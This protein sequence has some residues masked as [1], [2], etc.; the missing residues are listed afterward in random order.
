MDTARERMRNDMELRRYSKITIDE[1]LRIIETFSEFHHR[2]PEKLGEREIE[3]YLLDVAS[4]TGPANQKM[5]VAALKFLYSTTLSKPELVRKIPWPRVPW[6]VRE[7]LTACE[8]D[9]ILAS[10]SSPKHR[11]ILAI[12]YSAGLRIGEAL[13]LSCED[14]DTNRGLIYIRK[15]KNGSPRYVMLSRR[16]REL[17]S[18]YLANHRPA[19]RELFP[20]DGGGKTVSRETLQCA[21]RRAVRRAGIQRRV[22]THSLRH[23]FATHLLEQGQDIRTLQV[24]LGH[25]SIETTARYAQVSLNRIAT[26]VSPFDAAEGPHRQPTPLRRGPTL[27]IELGRMEERRRHVQQELFAMSAS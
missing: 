7:I 6:K 20:G 11:V 24:L 10:V 21:M 17:L 12:M 23:S 4:R 19:G 27:E 1:Y 13:A 14:I 15:S 2:Q 22:T 3:S 9:Q 5:H 26:T 8:I 25:S 16:V 18:S